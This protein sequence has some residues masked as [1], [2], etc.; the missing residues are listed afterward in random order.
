[1]ALIGYSPC[2]SAAPLPGG[3][4]LYLEL[5]A[6]CG[7]ITGM[8]MLQTAAFARVPAQVASD[9]PEGTELLLDCSRIGEFAED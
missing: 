6:D 1:M 9:K 4:K 8:Q 5:A 2:V 7:Q 3:R